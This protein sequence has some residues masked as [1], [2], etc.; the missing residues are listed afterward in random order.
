MDIVLMCKGL[1]LQRLPVKLDT[2]NKVTTT[3]NDVIY[4]IYKSI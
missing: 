1:M 4:I 2:Q 3:K